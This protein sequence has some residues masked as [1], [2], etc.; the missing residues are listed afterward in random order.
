MA[1][2]DMNAV[3]KADTLISSGSK[4]VRSCMLRN[5]ERKSLISVD[6]ALQS[7]DMIH[8]IMSDM[9]RIVIDTKVNKDYVRNNFIFQEK[10]KEIEEIGRMTDING[11]KVLLGE[12]QIVVDRMKDSSESIFKSEYGI[13]NL[14]IDE[15]ILSKAFCCSAA[16]T[17]SFVL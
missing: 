8:S 3:R 16:I 6:V 5:E 15:G 9:M 10:K 4:I 14:V 12:Q 1:Y 13:D 11:T 2:E 7:F 17:S